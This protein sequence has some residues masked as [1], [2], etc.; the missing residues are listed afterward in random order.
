MENNNFLIGNTSSKGPFSI[1]MLDYRSV[2]GDS[3]A[4]LLFAGHSFFAPFAGGWVVT[5]SLEREGIGSTM[6]QLKSAVYWKGYVIA[7]WRVLD[8]LILFEVF[9]NL[10]RFLATHKKSQKKLP[11]Q[12][13]SGSFKK[14]GWFLSAGDVGRPFFFTHTIHVWYCIFTYMNG[15]FLWVFMVGKYS[16]RPMD[17][18]WEMGSSWKLGSANRRRVFTLDIQPFPPFSLCC[19][20]GGMLGG[21]SQDVT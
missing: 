19:L 16:F 6:H 3:F 17:P 1:A 20:L 21:S 18:S 2:K 9:P 13:F 12:T 10:E 5:L 4:T 11:N 14:I 7:P 15:W 8:L